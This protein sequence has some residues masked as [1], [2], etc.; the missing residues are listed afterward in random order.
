MHEEIAVAM[1]LW[2]RH[3]AALEEAAADPIRS[4]TIGRT[5]LREKLARARQELKKT[6]SPEYAEGLRGALGA[7]PF[8]VKTAGS[9]VVAPAAR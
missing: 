5:A 2:A 9:P 8:G 1:V 3:V 4:E 6:E 7:D